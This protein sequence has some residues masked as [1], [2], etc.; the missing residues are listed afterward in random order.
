[1]VFLIVSDPNKFI[2]MNLI[3]A[4]QMAQDAKRQKVEVES[5][6]EST[7]A[8]VPIVVISEALASFFGTEER[9][10]SQAEVL[11]QMWEYIKAHQLEVCH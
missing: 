1:M 4:E 10:M 3:F 5:G 11:R 9:E 6:S 8:P 2:K 7:D